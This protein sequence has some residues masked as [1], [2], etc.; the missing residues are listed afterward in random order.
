ME[1][2]DDIKQVADQAQK[3]Y[4]DLHAATSQLPEK[5]GPGDYSTE[6]EQIWA[7]LR[8]LRA[9]GS[10]GGGGVGVTPPFWLVAVD[11]ENVKVTFGQVNGITPT[12]VA[13]NI[14]VSGT[15]GTWNIYMHLDLGSDGIPTAAEVLSNTTS[16][17]SDDSTNAYRL[18]GTV[19]VS[20]GAITVVNPSMAW[21]QE[22]VTCGRDADDPGTTPGTYFWELA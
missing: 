17:P 8:K 19:T 12:D 11:T 20:S 6:L 18:I 7:E 5:A 16:V 15:D 10:G 4:A 9:A 22:F 3:R 2:G 21:S 13:T 14:D 1:P